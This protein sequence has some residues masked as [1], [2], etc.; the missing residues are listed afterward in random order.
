MTSDECPRLGICA[1][2]YLCLFACSSQ[3]EATSR[4]VTPEPKC[5]SNKDCE[6]GF[7]CE[8]SVG[9]CLSSILERCEYRPLTD[10]FRVEEEWAWNGDPDVVPGS[11]Q[12][13]M[14]PMVAN[15][16]DDNE[17]GVINE[18]DVPDVVFSSFSGAKP[19]VD[20]VLRAVSGDSGERIW[21][22][23]EPDY[24]VAPVEHVAIGEVASD[25][26]GPEIIACE[27]S[28][29]T[30][31]IVRADGTIYRRFDEEPNR[32]GCGK[33]ESPALGDMNGDGVVEIVVG[34]NIAHADGTR[35]TKVRNLIE[36]VLSDVDDDPDLELVSSN[37]VY[38]YDGTPLWERVEEDADRPPLPQGKVAVADMDADSNNPAPEIVVIDEEH[39]VWLLAA[40]TGDVI[41]GPV[42][43][44]PP[45]A[46]IQ[47]QIASTARGPRGG[48]RPVIAN[49]DD[50]PFPEIGV[51]GGFAY[52]VF[53]HDGVMQWWQSTIDRTS[54]VTGSSVF[55]FEG[56]G[57]FE[58][59]YSDERHFQVYRG[60]DGD[61]LHQQCNSSRTGTEFPV[62]ADVDNDGRAEVVVMANNFDF[63]CV[64]DAPSTTGI[65]VFG[66]PD[67]EWVGTRRIYN[68]YSYHITNVEEDG[69]IPKRET[70]NW[71]LPI[72][73]NYGNNIAIFDVPDLFLEDIEASKETCPEGLT[74]RVRVINR[75]A[76]LSPPGI[77]VSFF[78]EHNGEREFI[79]QGRT[80]RRLKPGENEVVSIDPPFVTDAFDVNQFR[81]SASVNHPDHDP[82]TEMRECH[83]DNNDSE[84]IESLG[85]PR[86]E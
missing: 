50:D 73:N 59:L 14:S 29:L 55:D 63:Q 21:P 68:Q 83:T 58:V 57:L 66:H 47:R 30:M 1:F 34:G 35:V 6:P 26:P 39:F 67:G 17:D 76:T 69:T 5:T 7:F 2:A 40:K 65:R 8:T 20:G 36:S 62:V 13:I 9:E 77:P 56:D 78:R 33:A 60:T 12:V 70:P 51:A 23:S 32:V 44:N 27:Q 16:T 25:S 84:E 49:F 24:L 71:S 31:I 45:D 43:I 82:V 28:T 79:G 38:D 72:F 64:D 41:W 80:S 86:L 37:G 75:G 10:G 81:L 11:D 19:F 54:R 74:I 48:G 85:C 3:P 46:E 42:D 22:T 53:G 4:S 18:D 61:E 52:A 15:L